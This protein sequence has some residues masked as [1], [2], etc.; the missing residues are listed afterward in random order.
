M[1]DS[2][3]LTALLSIDLSKA[4]DSI[5]HELLIQKLSNFGFSVNSTDYI[6]SY[7]M[8]RTQK[9]KFLNFTSKDEPVLSGVPQGSI[10][11]PLLFLMF[12]NDL[13]QEFEKQCQI[14]SYADDTQ[15]I[16]TAPN[17]EELKIKI[18]QALETAQNWFNKN[19]MKNNV[20]KTEIV[21][22][23]KKINEK[24]FLIKMPGESL[25]EPI[26][27]K[28]KNHTKV[29]GVYIDKGM[30]WD[31][32]INI[33]RRNAMNVVRNIHKINKFLPEKIRIDLYHALI[34]PLFNYADVI[35]GG[36]RKKDS[37]KLQTVQNF[38]A[39]SITGNRKYDSA[40]NSLTHLKLLNLEKRREIHE[41]VF[42]HKALTGKSS[43]N[44]QNEYDLYSGKINTRNSKKGK[45]ILPAHTTTRYRKSVLY[46][47]IKSWNNLPQIVKNEDPK[48]QKNNYQKFLIDEMYPV[49]NVPNEPENN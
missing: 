27:I 9:T 43:K 3:K 49:M 42:I 40:T 5:N 8:N 32:Q 36:C 16:I 31:K 39:K 30:K 23:S 46:R 10:L 44:L 29:L 45:L 34:S 7:L 25:K 41:T 37:K 18:K 4:F 35:W 21:V 1:L 11:G 33:V 6:K 2:K 17:R 38:A 13:S 12:T 28:P 19:T 47:T 24:N 48:K 20:G 22:F 15:L 14:F 26:I